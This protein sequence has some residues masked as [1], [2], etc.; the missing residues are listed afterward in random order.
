[1]LGEVAAQNSSFLLLKKKNNLQY[2]P[3]LDF[4]TTPKEKATLILQFHNYHNL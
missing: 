3:C 1:M 2:L 4:I